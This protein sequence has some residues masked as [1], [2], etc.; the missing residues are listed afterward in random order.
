MFLLIGAG[1]RVKEI[2]E[3]QS[4]I[5]PSCGR[6]SRMTTMV[7]RQELRLFF[8]PVFRWRARYYAKASCCGEMFRVDP[9]KGRALQHGEPVTLEPD[10]LDPVGGERLACPSCGGFIEASHTYCPHCGERL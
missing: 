3:G 5:C 10:D 2:G 6:F 9:E 1:P 8:I 4:M 7:E